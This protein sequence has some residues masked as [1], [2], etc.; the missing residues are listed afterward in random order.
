[1]EASHVA[2]V[3]VGGQANTRLVTQKALIFLDIHAEVFGYVYPSMLSI[4]F[5]FFLAFAFSPL[6][7]IVATF[8]FRGLFAGAKVQ[9]H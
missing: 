3:G 6:H 7:A 5:F 8:Y 1:L 2:C 9:H 4:P